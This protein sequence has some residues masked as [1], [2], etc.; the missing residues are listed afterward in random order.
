MRTIFVSLVVSFVFA[1]ACGDS[2]RTGSDASID[3]VAAIDAA[4]DAVNPPSG[5]CGGLVP[6][7]CK[8]NEYCDYVDNSCGIADGPGTCKRRPDACPLVIGPV[9]GCDGKVHSSDCISFSDGVDVAANGR[10][11]RG[12]G[13]LA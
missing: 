6:V 8:S 9:C 4:G 2:D 3:A 5:L 12:A 1:T 10:C 13:R 11:A 7:E